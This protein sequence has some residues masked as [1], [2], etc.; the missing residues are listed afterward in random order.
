QKHF[1]GVLKYMTDTRLAVKEQAKSDP[2]MDSYQNSLKVLINGSGYG[3]LGTQGYTYNCYTNAALITAYGRKILLLMMKAIEDKG[4]KVIEVDTDGVFFTS[5]NNKE[6]FDYIQEQLPEGIS[7]EL[8]IDNAGAYIPLAK[9]YIL[10]LENGKVTSKGMFRSRKRYKL[11][12]EFPVEF[13]RKYFKESAESAQQYYFETLTSLKD[14]TIPIPDISVTRRIAANEKEIVKAGIGKVGETVTFW[15]DC[16]LPTGRKR[17]IIPK[18]VNQG[19]DYWIDYYVDRLN[20]QYQSLTK[21]V[22][23][24]E[25]YQQ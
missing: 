24:F 1:L 14:K 8:E 9:N 23:E 6:T 12:K 22:K 20:E 11:E 15:I 4:G 21:G 25:V 13:L 3:F 7:I 10:F 2:E 5:S 19:D 17:K 16:V 18:Y